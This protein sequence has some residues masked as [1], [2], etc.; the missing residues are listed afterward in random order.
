MLLAAFILHINIIADCD[1]CSQ[2][3]KLF[4]DDLEEQLTADPTY[5]K[6]IRDSTLLHRTSVLTATKTK[7]TVGDEASI[8]AAY[9]RL[10]TAQIKDVVEGKKLVER[11]A[12]DL[13]KAHDQS[14]TMQCKYLRY[15]PS[16]PK[17]LDES[18]NTT[19]ALG[20]DVSI[21]RFYAPYMTHKP[22][23]IVGPFIKALKPPT[24]A[25]GSGGTSAP[26]TG[27]KRAA[28]SS[29]GTP[30]LKKAKKDG[31]PTDPEPTL[32]SKNQFMFHV[33]TDD[34]YTK[35]GTNTIAIL[36]PVKY[37][38]DYSLPRRSSGNQ[39]V[40]YP[41]RKKIWR[42]NLMG[43]LYVDWEDYLGAELFKKGNLVPSLKA[44]SIKNP[45]DLIG[46]NGW[47]MKPDDGPGLFI[48][49]GDQSVIGNTKLVGGAAT[50]AVK[51]VAANFTPITSGPQL[52]FRPRMMV[53]D[54]PVNR[55]LR[56][57][58]RDDDSHKKNSA[59]IVCMLITATTTPTPP[60]D[61]FKILH[62]LGGDSLWDVEGALVSWMKNKAAKEDWSCLSPAMKL[63]HHGGKESTEVSLLESLA[64]NHIICSI[65]DKGEHF[66][67]HAEVLAFIDAGIAA[68][69]YADE[70]DFRKTLTT[71]GTHEL[72][73]RCSPLLLTNYPGWFDLASPS[74]VSYSLDP[75]QDTAPFDQ[76]FQE[77]LKTLYG[78]AG[79]TDNI[80]SK[81][82]GLWSTTR[83][84]AAAN[85]LG[86]KS[87]A[88]GPGK[89][90]PQK[91]VWDATLQ[92]ES[93]DRRV[94]MAEFIK[95]RWQYISPQNPKTKLKAWVLKLGLGMNAYKPRHQAWIAD[96]T[97][98]AVPEQ[99]SKKVT[100]PQP[101]VPTAPLPNASKKIAMGKTA[102]GTSVP[103]TKSKR[104]IAAPR[105]FAGWARIGVADD[106]EGGYTTLN[107]KADD[108]DDDDVVDPM[109]VVAFQKQVVF[110]QSV[111][112]MASRTTALAD[113]S[114]P[115]NAQ[116]AVPGRFY[117]Y[118]TIFDHVT[119]LNLH[120]VTMAEVDPFNAFLNCLD[121]GY[122]VLDG[123]LTSTGVK[124]SSDTQW[125]HALT[126]APFNSSTISPLRITDLTLSG[127][128]VSQVAQIT[129]ISSTVTDGHLTLLFSSL[130]TYKAVIGGAKATPAIADAFYGRYNL[131]ALG[132]INAT[133]ARFTLGQILAL[134]GPSWMQTVGQVDLPGFESELAFD[135]DADAE[136]TRNG[137]YFQ[138]NS[139]YPVW[140]RLQFKVAA[141]ARATFTSRLQTRLRFLGDIELSD[142]F[143][144][145][146]QS[147]T[148]EQRFIVA[149]PPAT[150]PP[151]PDSTVASTSSFVCIQ[152]N[153][154]ISSLS[155][156]L[157]LEYNSDGSTK[158]IVRF[159]DQ[160]SLTDTFNWLSNS[161]NLGNLNPLDILPD[162]K[163]VYL[164]QVALQL[165]S[166]MPEGKFS[167]AG[168]TVTATLEV[169]CFDSAFFVEVTYPS[170]KLKAS[171]WTQLSDE[172]E[173]R[174]LPWLEPY[175]D[176]DPSD[177][178]GLSSEGLTIKHFLPE[179]VPQSITIPPALDFRFIEAEFE[180]WKDQGRPMNMTFNA[181]LCAK[182]H[183][184]QGMPSFDLD[185]L[186][187]TAWRLAT[188]EEQE[189]STQM[190][191]SAIFYLLPRDYDQDDPTSIAAK[192][193]ASVEYESGLWT[194]SASA[195]ALNFA[196]LYGMFD[197]NASEH[198][199]DI[200]SSFSIPRIDF[201]FEFNPDET[202]NISLTG[203]LRISFLELDLGYWY[204][205]ADRSW[206]VQAQLGFVSDSSD[207]QVTIGSIVG[208]FE[209]S[210][211]EVL[212]EIEFINSIS[213]PAIDQD[214][215]DFDSAPI[216]FYMTSTPD[217]IIMWFQIEI[218]ADVGAFTFLF[219]QYKPIPKK[220][221][222]G[223][224]P[225]TRPSAKRFVRV[226]L[227][228]LPSLPNIPI[229]GRIG[230]PVDSISYCY[231]QD[232]E[233][234][235]VG[236]SSTGFTRQEIDAING[237]LQDR[238]A[239][240][241][242]ETKSNLPSAQ[243]G[244]SSS[245]SSAATTPEYVL[246]HGHHFVVVT[247]GQV[248]LDHKFGSAT[249]SSAGPP[250]SNL[251]KRNFAFPAFRTAGV[252]QAKVQ[253]TAEDSGAT[254]GPNS[255]K[256]SGIPITI[257]NFGV[258]VK[259][260]RLYLL[261]D[262]QVMLGPLS[263]TLEGFGIGVPLDVP[264]VSFKDLCKPEVIDKFDVKLTGVGVYF[265][266]LP[267]SIGGCF[268][269]IDTP[270]FEAYRGGLSVSILP[271]TLLA[272]G[273]YQHTKIPN[274][275]KSV[276]VFARLDGPLFTLEFAEISGVAA[277]FG[278]NYDLKLPTAAEVTDF[279]FVHGPE[280]SNDP[281]TLL[282][283]R[284]EEKS[285]FVNWTR[286][287]DSALFFAVGMKI[288]AFQ[289]LTVDAAA[290]LSFSAE[291][292]K[293]ALIGIASASMPPA[294]PN[295]GK[296]AE[297]FIYVELGI[298][299]SL[300]IVGGSLLVAAQLTP[301]SYILAPD[302]HLTGGFALC[303]YFGNN[304]NAGDWVFTIGGY[305]PA[306]KRP[307]HYPD[308]PRVGI[309]W[310]L[311]D[312]LTVRGESY[313]AICPKACMGGGRL[314]A[315][316]NAGPIYA[317]FEAWASFLINFK[318]FF[319][320]ADIGINVTVG[321]N[322]DFWIVHIHIHAELGADLHLQGPPFGGVAHVHFWVVGFS[323]YFGD[324]NDIPA[325]LPWS[326][327]LDLVKQP[328]PGSQTRDTAMCVVAI[329]KGSA[330]EKS[331][332]TNRDTGEKWFVRAGSF[333]FRVETKFPIDDMEYGDSYKAYQSQDLNPP[334]FTPSAIYAR[335]MQLDNACNSRLTVH[336]VPP[337]AAIRPEDDDANPWLVSP[338]IRSLPK[339]LWAKCRFTLITILVT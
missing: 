189:T 210:L 254:M 155:L 6:L 330:D 24:K 319:F 69:R 287:Q 285:S 271:Y 144:I 123:Q 290:I 258:Q 13:V 154:T 191:I 204:S 115:L 118:G 87:S 149:V 130:N 187:F 58:K 260:K 157:I 76:D 41:E 308:V 167:I 171:L 36:F 280:A 51:S 42:F 163:Y 318:P 303:Y 242:R 178:N 64:P 160:K 292:V 22:D 8:N 85:T 73:D 267:V 299:A 119:P 101:L 339:A 140:L 152:A 275:F 75:F 304:A 185:T 25:K 34:Q 97:F 295:S 10:T 175:M 16:M 162:P 109:N 231:V 106:P 252:P 53:I 313:F 222:D 320:V 195:A 224:L 120:E 29:S 67:P 176:V 197:S 232:S 156:T 179:D 93:D 281:L 241:F 60:Q 134:F 108:D 284:K 26:I 249:E 214:A 188:G 321:C 328:G 125:I 213:V 193:M 286:A 136:G 257:N 56:Y 336:V 90:D 296:D 305:H 66:H 74:A 19:P 161:L 181:T 300:D 200:L 146:R 227:D 233:S 82:T 1:S 55:G 128:V 147:T 30:D 61:S 35:S 186:A 43:K 217:A 151:S 98:Q 326:D 103:T 84:V 198:V 288:D 39:V 68:L 92:K 255:R 311:S 238:N 272:V 278:Y 28:P 153:V 337:G 183:D 107:I 138:A 172:D 276:F 99:P 261:I 40:W 104:A 7:F 225:S 113:V 215:S 265:Q 3:A 132:L 21:T 259:D 70:T 166:L 312:V 33:N 314:L 111:V 126:S 184:N 48:V 192:V 199:M 77:N 131:L 323:V 201:V 264:G 137:L 250:S 50:L 112:V 4:R 31:I 27:K 228:Q 110:K 253:A 190:E 65:A 316:F 206:T 297:A 174:M 283:S 268:F 221:H 177:S 9:A 223:R 158:L 246:L 324:Q 182:D 17:T 135:L 327:F 165:G 248:V 294:K 293:I 211:P 230:Q 196:T 79:L 124:I 121:P 38:L 291:S 216:Q 11:D 47:Q 49:A 95:A 205:S 57:P 279:P 12:W 219:A 239:I 164:R 129:Q 71:T 289:V 45:A 338:L 329:E 240:R 194:L 139:Q 133:P 148:T 114:P 298:V 251:V 273:A 245:S 212:E 88:K 301:N 226:R 247:D 2:V 269:H 5:Q 270:E 142:A 18:D 208:Q 277:G 331:T 83:A 334:G 202:F 332:S 218:D 96:G 209:P 263:L 236:Q 105:R 150:T 86:L 307:Q 220:D 117:I 54:R 317:S 143:V 235:K 170:F 116:N 310:N 207:K 94:K 282:S 32:P 325:P 23:G 63:S 14:V 266:Q 315:T 244:S 262:A 234:L 62:F 173:P 37:D 122:L 59:S 168:S 309:S 180:T 44:A 169:D 72:R 100:Y 20:A 52:T 80:F 256:F 237:T 159:V 91:P 89:S 78:L 302:C 141:D 127:T 243:G 333:Q 322:I 306:F 145:I 46:P 203:A 274:D 81:F 15:A 335:P 102:S 229:V